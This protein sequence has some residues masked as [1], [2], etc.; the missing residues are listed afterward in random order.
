M[1]HY[2][3]FITLFYKTFS[4]VVS[5]EEDE[6]SLLITEFYSIFGCV[7]D[8]LHL[9]KVLPGAL[10]IENDEHFMNSLLC[11][12]PMLE[13]EAECQKQND[14]R[15]DECIAKLVVLLPRGRCRKLFFFSYFATVKTPQKS[16]VSTK[17]WKVKRAHS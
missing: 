2:N 3:R 9:L 4:Y 14:V 6:Q 12:I 10:K 17:E 5:L 11:I 1:K 13:S 15:I 16:L 7:D 8:R